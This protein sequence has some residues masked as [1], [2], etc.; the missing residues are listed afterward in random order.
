MLPLRTWQ[1]CHH[2][3]QPQGEGTS[4][5]AVAEKAHWREHLPHPCRSDRGS[6]HTCEQFHWIG[7][8][9]PPV[10]R[11]SI[12]RLEGLVLFEDED[13]WPLASGI[14]SPNWPRC[15]I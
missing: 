6:R 9:P 2:F 10:A 1:G 14:Q 12:G 5:K 3:E 15:S 7:H 11:A 4:Q 8:I 13:P